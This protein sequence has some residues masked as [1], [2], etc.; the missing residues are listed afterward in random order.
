MKKVKKHKLGF[1]QLD[2]IPSQDELNKYYQS[3][4]D[5]PPAPLVMD[6]KDKEWIQ[7]TLWGDVVKLIEEYAPSPINIVDIG[8]GDNG[9][10]DH[11]DKAGY[12]AYGVD[13]YHHSA[14]FQSV[15]EINID[16][17]VIVMLNVLEHVPDPAGLLAKINNLANPQVLIV[18][19][20]NDFSLM[21][22]AARSLTDYWIS[23]PDHINYFNKDS[24]ESL[25]NEWN[26][27]VVYG[28]GDFPM[29]WF[30]LMGMNYINNANTGKE[31]HI[32]RRNL[33][34]AL[35]NN[36][37]QEIYRNLYNLGIGRNLLIAAT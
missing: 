5:S 30:L 18:K 22:K 25:L 33:E 2:P 1:W 20:P 35:P 21:Q 27:S 24:L 3:Y 34:M 29:E 10:V 23:Y 31:C 13:A 4:W 8:S 7:H 19:V 11:L 15:E 36:I 9:L 28:Q 12:V 26:W 14:T 6:D 32:M 37:R 16:V 17:D